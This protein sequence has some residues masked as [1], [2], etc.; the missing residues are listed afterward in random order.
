MKGCHWKHWEAI[1]EAVELVLVLNLYLP[2]SSGKPRLCVLPLRLAYIFRARV[3]D[4]IELR[5]ARQPK[6]WLPDLLQLDDDLQAWAASLP[7]ELVYSRRTLYEY[8]IVRL[9]S[10]FIKENI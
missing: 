6:S 7:H 1:R 5:E 8:L 10:L 4:H 9:L 2:S 3:R